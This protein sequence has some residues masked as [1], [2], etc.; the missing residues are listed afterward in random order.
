MDLEKL[1][2]KHVIKTT[3]YVRGIERE[4][5]IFLKQ[6]ADRLGFKS[7][8]DFLNAMV[9]QLIDQSELKAEKKKVRDAARDKIRDKSRRKT[10][11]A[12]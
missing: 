12:S 2:K 1:K 5:I 7:L 8:G 11:K 10:K 9:G 3:L 4:K 6:E